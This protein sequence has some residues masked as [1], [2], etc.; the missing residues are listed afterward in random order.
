M[1]LPKSTDVLIVGAGP[2]GM[3]CANLL[4]HYGVKGVIIDKALSI[5]PKPRAIVLDN[6]ALRILQ[7]V[8]VNRDDFN[9]LGIDKVRFKSPIFGNIAQVNSAG[10]IDGHA[11][12]VTFVQPELEQALAKRL[13]KQDSFLLQRGWE[14][15][16]H[17]QGEEGVEALLRDSQ[18]NEHSMLCQFLIAGDGANSRVRQALSLDFKGGKQYD[19]DWLIIDVK[20]VSRSN[21]KQPQDHIEFLCDPRRAIPHMPAT[22]DRERWEFKLAKGEDSERVLQEDFIQQLLLPWFPQ[23]DAQVERKAVYRFKANVAPAF[24]KGRIFLIGDAAHVTPPFAGQ[25]LV[26]GLRD[27]A[28]LSWKIAQVINYKS[29]ISILDSYDQE[30]R[31]HA[32]A[33]INLAVWA[34]RVIMPQNRLHAFLAHGSVALISCL[35]YFR[36][37]FNELEIKPKNVFKKGLFLAQAKQLKPGNPL[38][39]SLLKH[40]DGRLKSS[41][42]VNAGC[43]RLIGFGVNPLQYLSQYNQGRFESIAGCFLQVCHKHQVLNRPDPTICWQDESGELLPKSASVGTIAVVRPDQVIMAQGPYQEVDFIL[44]EVFEMLKIE[45]LNVA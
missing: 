27:A 38:K 23:K 5:Y 22:G 44:N 37:L 32:K 1:S 6:E 33:M 45:A 29:H 11:K 42:D 26:A 14:L 39:Q 18:G 28:N 20:N 19:E 17:K 16:G 10:V 4:S 41:D 36:R 43:F 35:P 2:V 8:G 3:A 21:I 34:G 9:Y 13:S 40:D 7:W 15:V 24:S 31:P 25:G 12:L 30:R